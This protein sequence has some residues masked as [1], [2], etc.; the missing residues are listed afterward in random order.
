MWGGT[1]THMYTH[2]CELHKDTQEANNFCCLQQ[3]ADHWGTETEGRLYIS[4][5]FKLRVRGGTNSFS[6]LS[7]NSTWCAH[8]HAPRSMC[9]SPYVFDNNCT[10]LFPFPGLESTGFMLG[11]HIAIKVPNSLI[12]TWISL[13]Y[14]KQR[15]CGLAPTYTFCTFD[16]GYITY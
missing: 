10:D 2:A 11:G 1:H 3:G 14:Q 9:P 13:V 4:V 7:Q 6:L 8:C 5:F 15:V 12:L 16:F